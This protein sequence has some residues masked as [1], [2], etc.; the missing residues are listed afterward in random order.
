MSDSLTNTV[1]K[2]IA[3]REAREKQEAVIIENIKEYKKALN[4]MAASPSGEL[5]LKTLIKV[6]GAYAPNGNLDAVSLIRAN[7]KSDIY[8][9]FIRP[10][11]EPELK[12]KIES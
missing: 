1:D 6:C 11:L 3:S 9:E 8:L 7:A 2:L 4:D 10:F 5:V 12:Q